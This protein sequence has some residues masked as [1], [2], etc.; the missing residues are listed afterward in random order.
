MLINYD[1]SIARLLNDE[2]QEDIRRIIEGSSRSDIRRDIVSSDLDA[3]KID[4][5]SRDSY[6]TGVKYGIFDIEKIYDSFVYLSQSEQSYLGIDES[7]IFAIEQL[8]LAKYHMTQQVY[9]HRVRVITDY[10]IVRGLKLAIDDGLTEIQELYGYDGSEEYC[11][12]YMQYDDE[13]VT[14]IL[15]HCD[16]PKPKSIFRR[17]R[18][19]RLFKQVFRL[20]LTERHVT[21]SII[22]SLITG[23]SEEA[24]QEIETLVASVLKCE[25]WEVIVEVKNVKNPAYQ[26]I[27]SL[28][29]E[30]ILVK[31]SDGQRKTMQQYDELISVSGR[32]PSYNTLHVIAPFEVDANDESQLASQKREGVEEQIRDIVFNY[33]GG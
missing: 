27:G 28:D 1:S 23:L 20:P 26:N 12:Q 9:A 13:R 22:L 25:P 24:K 2:Q 32:F 5:L 10:M 8:I 14:D 7:G 31:A 21:D 15:V 3:D 6:F 19:R 11:K 17:L 29:P 30:E 16:L 4:Y 18:S 33:V